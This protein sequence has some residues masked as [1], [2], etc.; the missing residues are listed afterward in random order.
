MSTNHTIPA[1][2]EADALQ[3]IDFF[4]SILSQAQTQIQSRQTSPENATS[5]KQHRSGSPS[6]WIVDRSRERS[7]IMAATISKVVASNGTRRKFTLVIFTVGVTTGRLYQKPFNIS[8]H[9]QAG[10]AK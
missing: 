6:A 5:I 4:L 7:L 3:R 8:L 1:S 2:I 9:F 10:G